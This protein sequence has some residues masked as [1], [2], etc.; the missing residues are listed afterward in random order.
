[1]GMADGLTR[2]LVTGVAVVTAFLAI[3]GAGTA[4]AAQRTTRGQTASKT[5]TSIL[6]AGVAAGGD[7][8]VVVSVRS[9]AK[10]SRLVR[11]Y[12]A[13]QRARMIV[14]KPSWGARVDYTVNLAPGT[15]SVRAVSKPPAVQIKARLILRPSDASAPTK[16]STTPAGSGPPTTATTTPA[17]STAAS[18]SAPT[19]SPSHTPTPTP[20]PPPAPPPTPPPPPS[21]PPQ[22]KLVWSDEFNGPAGS[23]AS[24]ANWTRSTGPSCVQS[25]FTSTCSTYTTAIANAHLDGNGHLAI[26]AQSNNGNLTAAQLETTASFRYGE[27]QASMELPPGQGLW[28]GFWMV[29]GTTLS[30]QPCGSSCGEIDVLEA[31]A[32]GPLPT[33]AWFTLHGPIANTS[34][35]QQWETTTSALGSLAGA[36]HTYGIIWT[37]GSIT[38]TIDG[39]AYATATPNS[40][41]PGSTWEFDSGYYHLLLDLS[42]GGWPGAPTAATAFPATLLVDWVRVYQL[43]P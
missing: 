8:A 6:H 37:P 30:S 33:T 36:F 16:L 19:P 32:F 2:R 9:V 24:S 18:T 5:V 11:V 13:G 10:H 28:A 39:V 25:Q 21:P 40:L 35:T 42:I 26:V 12:L 23:A 7:Y 4:V 17:P 3:A 27:I 43:S 34:A 1:M 29:Q 20:P 31:P 22:Y 15:L 38:W 14:A 41:A